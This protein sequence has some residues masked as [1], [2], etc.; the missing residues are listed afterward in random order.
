[1][2]K[3][4]TLAAL[5]VTVFFLVNCSNKTGKAISGKPAKAHSHFND[6]TVYT[7]VQLNEGMALYK[8]SCA[9][10]HRLHAASEFN[11]NDWD[12]IL[13]GMLPRTH[14]SESKGLTVRAYLLANAKKD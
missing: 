7:P 5:S 6:T 12:G 8:A 4:C 10:C 13:V 2:K 9:E 1:M 3:I 11:A 14:L